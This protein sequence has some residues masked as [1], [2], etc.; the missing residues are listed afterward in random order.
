MLRFRGDGAPPEI[1]MTGPSGQSV[2][3][4]PP[5]GPM[6]IVQGSHLIGR[7]PSTASTVVQLADTGNGAW[8]YS[9]LPGS[10]AVSAVEGAEVAPRPTVR[11][12]VRL[13]GRRG[14][15]R[16]TS[17]NVPKGENIVFRESGPGVPPRTIRRTSLA[18]G[19]IGF[20]PFDV[21]ERRRVITATIEQNGL[22]RDEVTVTRY[23]APPARKLERPR[24]L[25]V[26]TSRGRLIAV[27]RRDLA[28]DRYE[29]LVSYAD[30]RREMFMTRELRYILRG[31]RAIGVTAV[32]VRSVNAYGERGPAS[33]VRVRG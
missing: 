8:R 33:R 26:A 23:V 4:P 9:L 18:R 2:E 13:R 25:A 32:Q 28:A 31:D 7:D 5:G 1:H 14:T 20:T 11:G 19:S 3:M 15:L 6:T 17:K 12:S 21:P 27:W 30:G 22:P 29:I 10:P 16:W 24:R